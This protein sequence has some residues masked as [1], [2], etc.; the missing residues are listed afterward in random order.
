MYSYWVT[1]NIL[2]AQIILNICNVITVIR[3]FCIYYISI[4]HIY[5]IIDEYKCNVELDIE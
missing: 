4:V 5:N 2:V 1:C 3:R